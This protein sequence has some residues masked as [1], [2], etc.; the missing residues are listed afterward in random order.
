M[1]ISDL[2]KQYHQAIS[3]GAETLTGTKGVE[4][5]VASLRSLTKGNIFE[6]T[7]TSVKN[8]RVTLSFRRAAG[9]G[10]AGRK[11][12][13]M[14]GESMFFQVKSND[15]TQIAIRPFAI[16][17]AG[18]NYTLMQAL[19]AAGLSAQPEYL[20]MV[21]RMMEEQMPIDRESLQQMA[22]LVN[23]NPRIDVQTL[24]QMQKL[25]IPITVEN[26]S[27]FENYMND[28]QAITRELDALIEQFPQSLTGT[29]GAPVKTETMRQLGNELLQILTDGL[30]EVPQQIQSPEPDMAYNLD[31]LNY[32]SVQT[33]T[34]ETQMQTEAAPETATET[35]QEH[36]EILS[37]QEGQA[38]AEEKGVAG[39]QEAE[40]ME[41]VSGKTTYTGQM[42]QT[43]HTLGAVLSQEQLQHLNRMIGDILGKPQ[44]AYN[45]NSGTVEVLKDL[46]QLCKDPLPLEREHLGKLFSSREF[47]KLVRDTAEQQW[48]VKPGDLKEGDYVGRLYERLNSQME[49]LSLHSKMR[50][51]SI[52]FFH[53]WQERSTAM[54]NL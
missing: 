14:E 22:R 15:G 39:Q 30:E 28:S 49:K 18:A 42:S 6:G 50:D 38:A 16:D 29:E 10:T 45:A 36:P 53:R 23:A 47:Q 51:R 34:A 2:V 12:F 37:Q 7:V 35:V 32:E 5:L 31:G 17:G 21:D 54:W 24:V 13:L 4:N 9:D 26:A 40:T 8:G 46:Q 52:L 11:D 44:S 48:M 25:G 3:S 33:D 1:Q 27:Q 41:T 43:P 20:S 19:S